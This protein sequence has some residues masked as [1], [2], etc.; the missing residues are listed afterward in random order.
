MRG[1][2]LMAGTILLGGCG[3]GGDAP[4]KTA[5]AA[6]LGAG[7]Y[8]VTAEVTSLTSTDKSAPATKL[9]QGDKVAARACVAADG[10]PDAALVGEAGDSCTTPSS[11][12]RNG[13]MSV[14]LVCRRAGDSGGV[15]V[16]MDGKFTADGFEGSAQ[17]ETQFVGTGDYKMTR[18][19]TAKRVGDCPAAGAPAAGAPAAGAPAA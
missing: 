6:K 5:A 8:E 18:K 13:R 3:S 10:T 16:T 1:L 19:L 14:Q 4:A 9:K 7:L 11:Y 2:I 12:V 17:S 15:M